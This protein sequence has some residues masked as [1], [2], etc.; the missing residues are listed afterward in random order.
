MWSLTRCLE[1]V[2]RIFQGLLLKHED[3]E[4]AGHPEVGTDPEVR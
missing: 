3:I 4:R 1:A 2:G